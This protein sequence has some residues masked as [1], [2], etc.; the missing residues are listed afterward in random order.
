MT[1][2]TR[3]GLFNMNPS[4]NARVEAIVPYYNKYV[5]YI[6]VNGRGDPRPEPR[7]DS[8]LGQCYNVRLLAVGSRGQTVHNPIRNIFFDFDGTLVFHEPDSFDVISEF[9][10]QIGQP[11]DAETDRQG[12]RTRHEYFVDPIIRDQL[13]GLSADQF[14]QHFNRHLLGAIG[15]QGNLDALAREVTAHFDGLDLVYRCPKAGFRTLSELR[16]RGYPLGLITNRA[17]VDRFYEVF[18]QMALRPYFDLTLASGE[19]G[20]HKPN[21]GIFDVALERLGA[22]AEESLYVGD[23]YWADVV[24]ARRAGITPVLLDPHG[25]FPEA[26]CLII[27]RID[28]LLSWLP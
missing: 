27:E 14:W 9:C 21:P 10:A 25:L 17:N 2:V 18:D 24:G 7:F 8:A 28:E 22:K 4:K 26:D 19:V 23:N 5:N 3:S 1:N 11:L 16:A 15:V 20:V 6:I 13:A 12:R